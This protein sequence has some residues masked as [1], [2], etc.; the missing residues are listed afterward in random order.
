MSGFHRSGWVGVPPLPKYNA[1]Q[2]AEF[3]FKVGPEGRLPLPHS[4]DPLAVDGAWPDGVAVVTLISVD[5]VDAAGPFLI[6]DYFGAK[7]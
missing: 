1:R 7:P 5:K 3:A 4:V 2:F 6:V